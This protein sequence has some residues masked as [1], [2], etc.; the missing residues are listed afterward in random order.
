MFKLF[1]CEWLRIYKTIVIAT[2]VHF[3]ILGLLINF[4][5]FNSDSIGFK[6]SLVLFYS[7]CGFLLGI[8]QIKKYTKPNQ[9]AYYINR[10]I[11]PKT[12][13]LALFLA[14]MTAIVMVIVIPFFIVT[15]LL[16]SLNKE[17]IDLRHYHQLFYILGVTLSFYLLACYT[18]LSQ[19]TSSFLL[20]MVILLPIISINMGGSVYW[21]L[22]GVISVLFIMV[23]SIIKVLL[24]GQPNGVLNRLITTIAY[25]YSLYFIITALFFMLSEVVLDISYKKRDQSQEQTFNS[26]RYRDII[27]FNK[28]DTLIT[29]LYTENNQHQDLIEEIKLGQT[30]RIRK[31]IWFQPTQQQLP[32]MDENKTIINDSDNQVAWQFSH[33]L[34]LFVGKN[35][36]SRKVIGYLGPDKSFLDVDDI[37]NNQVFASVPWVSWVSKN[38]I[39]V[40]NKIYQYQYSQ[41]S[42]RLLFSASDDEFLLNI[43]QSQGSI[44]TIISNKN[45]YVFD[46]IDYDNDIIPLQEQ[47]VI[48]LSD[49]YNNLWDVQVTEV[50]DRFIISFL[51]G[52]STRHDI[53]NAEQ[54]VYEFTL[55]GDLILLNK[56][57]LE[58]SPSMLIKDLGYLL[59]PVWKLALDYF[60]LHPSRDRYLEQ[61]PQVKKL[62]QSTI[63]TLILLAIFYASF[64]YILSK[65]RN[66]TTSRKLIWVA[67][68]T[69]TGLPG[70]LSFILLNPKKNTL[71]LKKF[72]TEKQNGA[73]NV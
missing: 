59:S 72:H 35:T 54:L 38:Q 53:Y 16:D 71:E 69:I 63:T 58:H 68:N 30:D 41:Q 23:N 62:P 27:F 4:G 24:N 26:N 11:S 12:I 31:R 5:F 48:P 19:T 14:A 67:L 18:T 22:F 61:R 2:L 29:G 64:S 33:D 9:W 10:P 46:S 57:K 17:I 13:Y 1:T 39:V 37:N 44:K 8:T 66:L 25:Q 28:Q 70:I 36:N 3:L 47:L 45:I 34:M 43:L 56:R 65:N 20:I 32:F 15:L 40:K 60:P 51:Y 21:L 7:G 52:K 55:S 50:I 49:D 73:Q 42:F 6:M